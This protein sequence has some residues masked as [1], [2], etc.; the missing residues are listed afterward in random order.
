MKHFYSQTKHFNVLFALLA[1]LLVGVGSALAQKALPYEYGFETTLTEEGWTTVS[2][3]SS[4]G[5]TNTVKYS[6]TQSFRFYYRSNPPQYLISP[7]LSVPANATNVKVSFYYRAQ[8]TSYTES[9][10]VGYS[11]TDNDVASF[12]WED[13]TSTN[14]TTFQE[15]TTTFPKETKYIAI[16]Y[17]AD[18]QYYLFVDDI[19]LNFDAEGSGLN[20]LDGDN[21]ITSGYSYDFGMTPTGTT[22]VFTL[23]NPGTET[24][25]ISVSHTG[26]F[27]VELSATSIPAGESVTLTVTMP[28]TSGSD[29]ITMDSNG[30]NYMQAERYMNALLNDEEAEQTVAETEGETEDEGG[31]AFQPLGITASGYYMY[32]TNYVVVPDELQALKENEEETEG[33]TEKATEKTT[34]KATEKAT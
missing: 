20:V 28:E 13:E 12:T 10:K 8:S 34:E 1:M 6:G 4:S 33:E 5:I 11:T 2:A 24:T 15:Y 19:S 32:D 21:K 27:G 16:A 3:H 22:K 26:N 30:S 31:L 29:A 14:N 17:T 23:S 18:Y 9:F 25:N 7:E